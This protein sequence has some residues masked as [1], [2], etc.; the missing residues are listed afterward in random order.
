MRH[1][2]GADAMM[3]EVED[4]SVGA[5]DGHE[6]A[7]LPR[8]LVLAEVRHVLRRVLHPRVQ[9][10]PRVAHL[11]GMLNLSQLCEVGVHDGTSHTVGRVRCPARTH[12]TKSTRMLTWWAMQAPPH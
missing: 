4:G 11:Q 10:Q 2:G 8:P 12:S 7:L 5:V 1:V 9:H 6:G 3:Q